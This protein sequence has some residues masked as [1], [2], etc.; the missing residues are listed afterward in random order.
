MQQSASTTGSG[1][2]LHCTGRERRPFTD[3]EK[4]LSAAKG[5]YP[6]DYVAAY[7]GKDDV[8]AQVVYD[9]MTFRSLLTLRNFGARPNDKLFVWLPEAGD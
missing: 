7:G 4:A 6:I 8:P 2:Q 1:S 9:P 5:L 3:I